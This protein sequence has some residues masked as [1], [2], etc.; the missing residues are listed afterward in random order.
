MPI[1]TQTGYHKA[2]LSLHS[3]KQYKAIVCI[4]LGASVL[5]R[6]DKLFFE[7]LSSVAVPLL[8]EWKKLRLRAWTEIFNDGNASWTRIVGVSIVWC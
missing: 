5:H 1:N 6:S 7:S 4:I 8:E 2:T 3:T